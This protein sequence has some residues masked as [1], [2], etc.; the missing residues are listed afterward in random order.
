MRFPITAFLLACLILVETTNSTQ[1]KK[2]QKSEF[3]DPGVV[4]SD[5]S[6]SGGTGSTGHQ[7]LFT[8]HADRNPVQIGE[9]V[10]FAISFQGGSVNASSTFFIEFTRRVAEPERPGFST[11]VHTC[12]PD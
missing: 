1:H 3:K 4:K 8:L 9:V 10:P 11:P 5:Q 2:G 7:S 6:V 12:V